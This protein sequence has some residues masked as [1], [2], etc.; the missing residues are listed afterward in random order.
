VKRRPLDAET[1]KWSSVDCKEMRIGSGGARPQ[2]E[3]AGQVRSDLEHDARSCRPNELEQSLDLLAF[4]RDSYLRICEG[5]RLV[6]GGALRSHAD[7]PPVVLTFT[8]QG[9]IVDQP[10]S[11][12]GPA[13]IRGYD[14][15][16]GSCDTRGSCPSTQGFSSRD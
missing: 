5:V 16:I 15:Q 6:E 9:H 12:L 14:W 3:R 8:Y 1:T 10:N 11:G 4:P 2:E 13:G 7:P